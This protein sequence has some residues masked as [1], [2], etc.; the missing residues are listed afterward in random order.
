MNYLVWYGTTWYGI[1]WYEIAYVYIFQK[2][3]EFS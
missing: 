1:A 3:I 2:I